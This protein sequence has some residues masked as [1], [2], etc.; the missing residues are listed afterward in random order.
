MK[1]HLARLSL[2]S[3]LLSVFFLGG[4]AFYGP[5][6]TYEIT[7]TKVDL[8][9]KNFTVRKLGAQGSAGQSFLFGV[10]QGPAAFGIPLDKHDV[11]ARAWRELHTNWDGKGSVAFHNINQEWT[12][13]GIPGIFIYHMNTITADIYEFNDEYINYASRGERG[14]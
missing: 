14:L 1:Q 10:P 3:V 8:E 4:C 12:A 5:Q 11:Q 2:V 13:Y 7:K 9:S 6:G